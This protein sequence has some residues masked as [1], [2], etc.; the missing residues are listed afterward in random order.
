MVL[1]PIG[2]KM[3]R[4]GTGFAWEFRCVDD[5]ENV[6]VVRLKFDQFFWLEVLAKDLRQMTAIADAEMAA[7]TLRVE[8]ELS[9]AS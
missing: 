5:R 7:I 4:D 8:A 2:C 9:A 6:H 3:V 1:K